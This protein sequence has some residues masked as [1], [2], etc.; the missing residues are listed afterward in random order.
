MEKAK[1]NLKVISWALLALVVLAVIMN[2]ITLCA[3]GLPTGEVPEGLTKEI[4]DVIAIITCVIGYI[5][6][7]PQIYVGIKGVKIAN[8]ADASGK[9]HKIWAIILG[10]FAVISVIS[11][12]SD[13]ANGFDASK[14]ISVVNAALDVALYVLY[15]IYADRISKAQ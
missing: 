9:A 11:G 3:N 5:V 14:L 4:A 6:F 1:Q 12:L 7:I 10:V 8:G 2:T 13:F 15:Y